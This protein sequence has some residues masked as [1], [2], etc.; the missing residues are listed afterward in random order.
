M[1]HDEIW[2]VFKKLADKPKHAVEN[3]KAILAVL[4]LEEL[5]A[6][7]STLVTQDVQDITTSFLAAIEQPPLTN[8]IVALWLPIEEY[9]EADNTFY[10]ARIIGCKS[11]DEE[12]N[13]WIKSQVYTNDAVFILDSLEALMKHKRITVNFEFLDWI[14]PLA[15]YTFVF[16]EAIQQCNMDFEKPIEIAI[17]YVDGDLMGLYPLK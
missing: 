9:K 4:G 5:E 10:G 15:L 2:E 8:K 17:G 12:D 3:T 1:T 16:N 14:L 7:I 11:F 6:E 13:F